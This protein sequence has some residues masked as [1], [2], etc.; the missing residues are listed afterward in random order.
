MSRLRELLDALDSH[1]LPVHVTPVAEL[2][3]NAFADG[4]AAP[5]ASQL[6]QLCDM[7]RTDAVLA[8]IGDVSRRFG[9]IL[10]NT[11]SVTGIKGGEKVNVIP[12]EVTVDLDGR[13]LPGFESNDLIAEIRGAVGKELD[14]EVIRTETG[15]A[16]SDLSMLPVLQAIIREETAGGVPVP[17]MLAGFTDG[18]QFAKLGIQN[19]AF[20]PTL[21]P[22]GFNWERT[23]HSADERIPIEALQFGVQVIHK[24]LMRFGAS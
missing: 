14:L 21:M 24:T 15:P 19:Y 13:L 11:V 4:L 16:K 2:S 5:L 9:P 20:L 22:R 7:E 3:I 18:C 10:H 17:A 23:I 12:S 8:V 6:R 1:W